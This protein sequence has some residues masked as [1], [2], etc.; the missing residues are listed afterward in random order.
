[1]KYFNL[2]LFLAVVFSAC[3]GGE[4]PKKSSLAMKKQLLKEK[5]DSLK[6]LTAEIE[7][8]KAEIGILDT[9]RV[10]KAPKLV[11]TKLVTRKDFKRFI[12]IQGAVEADDLVSA[13]SEMGGRITNMTLKEGDNIRKGQLVANID[14]EGVDKQIAELEK[15]LELAKD[16]YDRQKRLWDQQI[17][18]EIQYL[19]A[20]NNKERIEK[21]M[22]TVRFQLTKSKV[23]APISGVVDRVMAKQGEMAGPG[24]PIVQ[25][26]NTNKVKVVADVPESYLGSV[27]RGETVTI[28]FPAIDKEIKGRVSLLGRMID[29]ANRTFGV[30][31]N[32]PNGS[33]VYKPNLL[34]TMLINDYAKKDAVMIPLVLIQQEVNGDNFVF[35]KEEG[36]K[37]AIAKKV[38]IKTGESFEGETVVLEGLKGGEEIIVSG[39]RGLAENEKIKVKNFIKEENN[40]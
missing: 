4:K 27:K 21:S 16:L 40:G 8:L 34:A 13:S 17:G 12:E 3:G 7:S 23:Y 9:T 37:G 25:I 36:P 26:L 30:E 15:S 28:K 29:P 33:G 11:D 32:L 39:A 24:T 19:Q 22:E 18:S 20:K 14:M 38:Y 5:K 2:I 10:V 31:V 6:A 35:V 1:M